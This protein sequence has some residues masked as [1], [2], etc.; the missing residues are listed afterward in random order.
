MMT[1]SLRWSSINFKISSIASIPK[2]LPVPWLKEYAS[3]INRT[4]PKADSRISLVFIAVCPTYPATRSLLD[5]SINFFWLIIPFWYRTSP[6]ILATV[7]F[8]VPGFPRKR[9]CKVKSLF[10]CPCSSLLWLSSASEMKRLTCSFTPWIPIS[11]CR[12]SI[13][14]SCFPSSSCRYLPCAKTSSISALRMVSMSSSP[15]FITRSANAFN[16][17]SL[18]LRIQ[19]ALLW[20]REPR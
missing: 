13:A 12:R 18:K 1:M 9:E 16:S 19:R 15:V 3:S 10:S 8:P 2:S 17:F 7:V 4:P 11:F 20:S 5:T 14:S 6:I